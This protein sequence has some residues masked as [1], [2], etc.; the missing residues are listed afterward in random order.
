VK[1]SQVGS[2]LSIWFSNVREKNASINGPVCVKQQK[3][4]LK[5]W[6]K[7]RSLELVGGL[8]GGKSERILCKSVCMVQ[9]KVPIFL[10]AD[11]WIKR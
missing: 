10:A 5:L 9:K 7:K 8:T 4:W 2:A 1:D 11:E 6:A 3:N